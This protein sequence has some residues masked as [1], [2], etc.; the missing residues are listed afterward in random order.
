MFYVNFI[1]I[2]NFKTLFYEVTIFDLRYFTD[3]ENEID[4][5][6]IYQKL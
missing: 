5:R 6:K 3:T 1:V 2:E 4:K